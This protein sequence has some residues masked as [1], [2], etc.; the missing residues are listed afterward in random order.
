[1][2]ENEHKR[3]SNRSNLAAVGNVGIV[4]RV[5]AGNKVII[6]DGTMVDIQPGIQGITMGSKVVYVKGGLGT[7]LGFTMVI[8]HG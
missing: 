3:P 7:N 2:A 8:G 4:V 6:D 5:L 1:M